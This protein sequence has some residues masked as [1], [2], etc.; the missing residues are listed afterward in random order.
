MSAPQRAHIIRKPVKRLVGESGDRPKIPAFVPMS[1]EMMRRQLMWV[2]G[3]W[4]E[5]HLLGVILSMANERGARLAATCRHCGKF[6]AAHE[7]GSCPKGSGNF[8]PREPD[9]RTD[10]ISVAELAENSRW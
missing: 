8:E 7:S 2:S 9:G 5:E 4:C 10:P 1:H 6:E 3:G